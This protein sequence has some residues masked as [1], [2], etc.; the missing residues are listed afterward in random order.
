MR[1]TY[2]HE[3]RVFCNYSL[4]LVIMERGGNEAESVM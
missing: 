1:L 2:M 3:M 4:Q